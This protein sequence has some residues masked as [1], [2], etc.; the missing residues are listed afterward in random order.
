MVKLALRCP[1][2]MV[3]LLGTDAAPELL[4]RSCTTTPPAGA[5]ALSVTVPVALLPPH[6][7]VGL[8]V[9]DSS[10]TEPDGGLTVSVACRETLPA[11][12]VMVTCVVLE[13]CWVAMVKLAEDCPAGTV[14]EPGT[15]A[16]DGLLLLNCTVKPPEGAAAV[17]VTVPVLLLPPTTV[18]GFSVRL[19]S[20][21][22]VP[23]PPPAA[24]RARYTFRRPAPEAMVRPL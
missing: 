24:C 9:S 3:I 4:L 12:A 18:L 1:A 10:E 16:T 7:E 15:L 19:L 20:E 22:V 6:T 21:G 5:G 13:T 11:L 2:G 23:P 14:M 17:R 8:I